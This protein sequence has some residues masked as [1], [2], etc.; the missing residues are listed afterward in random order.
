MAD[1]PKIEICECGYTIRRETGRCCKCHKL[2]VKL[3]PRPTID[4]LREKRE[5]LEL[6]A[7]THIC[8]PGN[9]TVHRKGL[10]PIVG[11]V[12]TVCGLSMD[13]EFVRVS[14][15]AVNCSTCLRES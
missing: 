10:E 7:S 9:P 5:A 15:F 8:L 11:V 2:R 13:S 12:F 4:E 6:E 14:K 3:M 1:K